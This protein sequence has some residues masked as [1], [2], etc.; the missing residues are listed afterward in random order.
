MK[1]ENFLDKMCQRVS[2]ALYIQKMYKG[3]KIRS[4]FVNKQMLVA[5]KQTYKNKAARIFTE[6][7]QQ[8]IERANSTN[9]CQKPF[10]LI[11]EIYWEQKF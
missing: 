6:A 3:F 10:M 4:K 5:K 9:A 1:V 7:I 2:A 8:V 11:Q